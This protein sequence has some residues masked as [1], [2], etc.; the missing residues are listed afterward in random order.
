MKKYLCFLLIVS[1]LLAGGCGKNVADPQ[2]TPT[3]DNIMQPSTPDANIEEP[4]PS[5]PDTSVAE[6]PEPEPEPVAPSFKDVFVPTEE[7]GV[8]AFHVGGSD[9]VA[10]GLELMAGKLLY[11]SCS[12]YDQPSVWRLI[13]VDTGEIKTKRLNRGIY[14]FDYIPIN[15]D[16]FA[17]YDYNGKTYSVYDSNFELIATRNLPWDDDEVVENEY[18]Y[19]GI[20]YDDSVFT[21]DGKYLWTMTNERMVKYDFDTMEEIMSFEN[22]GWY[23]SPSNTFDGG[24]VIS[25]FDYDSEEYQYKYIDYNTGETLQTVADNGTIKISPDRKTG[26]GINCEEFSSINVFDD[27]TS[28]AL[29]EPASGRA[30]DITSTGQTYSVY[31]DWDDRVIV[32]L[33]YNW[34]PTAT[35]V[36]FSAFSMDSGKLISNYATSIC[37]DIYSYILDA[38]HN[39]LFLTCSTPDDGATIYAWDYLH[40]D[41]SSVAQVYN[42]FTVLPQKLLDKRD[43]FEEKYGMYVY[44]GSECYVTDFDYRLTRTTNYDRM[45]DVLNVIEEVFSLYP[46]GFLKQILVGDIKTLGIYLCGGFEKVSD[47]SADSAIALTMRN[48]YE[49]TIAFDINC[50]DDSIRH[51]VVHEVSHWIDSRIDTLQQFGKFAEYDTEWDALNPSDFKYYYSYVDYKTKWQYIYDS[52]AKDKSKFYFTDSYSQT[53]PGED[54]ARL[55]EYLM[56]DTANV[57]Y[58]SMPHAREKLGYYF[59]VIRK[60]FD[61]TGWP[62][63]TSWEEKL[64]YYNNIYDDK[65]QKITETEK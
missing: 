40:D 45:Y 14:D 57:G 38:D 35:V 46:D 63:K 50:D 5:I 36:E 22:K 48:G 12:D 43:E 23:T 53:Y 61:T 11:S 56:Y 30:I 42:K 28:L 39:L 8:Y 19:G 3:S 37:A 7:P 64:M 15:N 10:S 2:N 24:F 52:M 16:E 21:P 29:P 4:S 49:N 62:E 17:L 41:V 34:N 54:R 6:E 9:L 27:L 18:Y 33:E 47:Y 1:L 25:G 60:V 59:D 58:M 32:T 26:I 31:P 20:Y 44:L 13:D 55:F 65:G 51:N